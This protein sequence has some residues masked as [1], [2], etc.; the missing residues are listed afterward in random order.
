MHFF[1]QVTSVDATATPVSEAKEKPKAFVHWVSSPVEVEVRLYEQLF[2][3]RNPEEQP[4]GFLND[5]NPDSKRVLRSLA[6]AHL[7]KSK[8]LD[9]FQFERTGFFCVDS[10]STRDRL[11]FNRTVTLKEDSK[12]G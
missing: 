9:R 5:V 2:L 3:H 10:D 8:A 1:I 7:V 12:K 4:G 6:D 11:V